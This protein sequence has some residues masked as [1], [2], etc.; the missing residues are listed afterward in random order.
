MA[1]WQNKLK[2]NDARIREMTASQQ[3][4]ASL[5]SNK[6]TI[7]PATVTPSDNTSSTSNGSV[8][9]SVPSLHNVSSLLSY[10]DN[11]FTLSYV[12]YG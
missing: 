10:T 2:D 12:I 8:Y 4:L 11:Q 5:S 9:Q 1:K 6:Q 3:N 7:K